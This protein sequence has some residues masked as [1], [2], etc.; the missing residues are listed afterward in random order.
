MCALTHLI[1]TGIRVE[2]PEDNLP[3]LLDAAV[4]V[5]LAT[6]GLAEV[7]VRIVEQVARQVLNKIQFY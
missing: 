6:N 5:V 3:G 7:S 4:D 1:L 2:E